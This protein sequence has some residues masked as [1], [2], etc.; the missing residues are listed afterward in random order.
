M[1][2]CNLYYGEME[3]LLL[4]KG[5]PQSPGS[6]KSMGS[7][8]QDFLARQVDD[9]I[10][11]SRSTSTVLN[12]VKRMWEGHAE[13]GVRINRDKTLV[14]Q[15][16]TFD[17]DGSD[18]PIE[19]PVAPTF[20]PWCGML[21]D[22]RTGEVYIDY[23]RFHNGKAKESLTVDFDGSEGRKLEVR[24]ESYVRPRCVP[25]LFDPLINSRSVIIINFYQLML[26]AAAKTVEHFRS[27]DVCP[28]IEHN[29]NFVLRCIDSLASYAGRQIRCNLRHQAPNPSSLIL[30]DRALCWLTWHAFSK[31]FSHLGKLGSLG[32]KILGRSQHQHR[33]SRWN[34]LST[35]RT[36]A[37]A[38]E[39][40]ALNKIIKL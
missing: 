34:S 31:V 38:F 39:R 14:S 19:P 21:F 6:Y 35:D 16:L 7:V 18:T 33:P 37:I 24:M 3:K 26:F 36:L 9:F 32:S 17:V 12:F 28:T 1:L 27:T 30:D 23:E 29:E 11:V 13:L 2:L 15:A 20:F 25:I 40:F 8:D 22:T 10:F 4:Y 5:N